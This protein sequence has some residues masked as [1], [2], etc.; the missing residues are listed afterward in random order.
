MT[1]ERETKI[2]PL[3]AAVAGIGFAVHLLL[4][5][6]PAPSEPATLDEQT[7]HEE[8]LGESALDNVPAPRP[9]ANPSGSAAAWPPSINAD[10]L[11]RLV[12]ADPEEAILRVAR[13][14]PRTDRDAQRLKLVEV[15]A[16][17][18]QGK[19]DAARGRAREYFER[20]PD[21]PDIGTLE[22]LTGAHP[23]R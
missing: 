20:W 5:G 21:G 23:A 9:V 17:V 14:L 2:L 10:E 12:A 1:P 13:S 6:E 18:A 16:L 15:R 8:E 4:G 11:D 19:L 3:L 7:S 22:Q